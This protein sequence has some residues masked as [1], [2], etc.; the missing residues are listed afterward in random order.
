MPHP[1]PEPRTNAPPGTSLLVGLT[2]EQ[3][4]AVTHGTGPLFPIAGPG[5]EKTRLG[6]RWGAAGGRHACTC[7][8]PLALVST[9]TPG[10]D[11]LATEALGLRLE[12]GIMRRW[13]ALELPPR[14]LGVCRH[15]TDIGRAQAMVESRRRWWPSS[16]PDPAKLRNSNRRRS[17]RS[18]RSCRGR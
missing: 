6:G 10:T 7:T 16:G 5:A 12:L 8:R 2:P 15:E 14:L 3:A 11:A 17:E 13:L 1:K 9:L 4:Q 18:R